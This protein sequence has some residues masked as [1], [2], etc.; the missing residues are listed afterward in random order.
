MGPPYLAEPRVPEPLGQFV[1]RWKAAHGFRQISVRTVIAAHE[2]ADA[3]QQT[4]KVEIV[5]V[6]YERGARR[7]E[8]EDDQ[9]P[10]STHD[11]G[12]L[13]QTGVQVG[14]IA[15]PKS[16]DCPIH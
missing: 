2:A 5:D 10:P 1:C 15:H 11:P 3:G 6:A 14:Q 4:M 9:T 16:D 7:R 8:F 13:A 12:N